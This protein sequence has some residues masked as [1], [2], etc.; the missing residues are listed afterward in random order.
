MLYAGQP[1]PACHLPGAAR[2]VVLQPDRRQLW[3]PIPAGIALPGWG[4]EPQQAKEYGQATPLAWL[5]KGPAK[6]PRVD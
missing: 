1:A 3:V 4:I 5:S 6:N 2:P